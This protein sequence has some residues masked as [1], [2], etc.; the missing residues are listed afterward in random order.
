MANTRLTAM[1]AIARISPWLAQKRP[2]AE[3][4]QAIS[5]TGKQTQPSAAGRAFFFRSSESKWMYVMMM[6]LPYCLP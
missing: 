5:G 6:R 4:R 3:S 2:K 1:Y